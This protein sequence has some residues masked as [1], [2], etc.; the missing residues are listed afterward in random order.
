MVSSV[1]SMASASSPAMRLALEVAFEDSSPMVDNPPFTTS[2]SRVNPRIAAP[3][4][5]VVRIPGLGPLAVV[6]W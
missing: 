5:S 2:N 1:S 6:F 3:I 4:G